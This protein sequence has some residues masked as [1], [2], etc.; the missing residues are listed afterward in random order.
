MRIAQHDVQGTF[1]YAEFKR[2]LMDSSMTPAQLGPFNQFMDT[3]KS[4]MSKTKTSKTMY[5][6]TP[7]V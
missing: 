6:W 7:K 1:S 4:F 5:G 2:Q 3:L